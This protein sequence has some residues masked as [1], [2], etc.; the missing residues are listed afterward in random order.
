MGRGADSLEPR[1]TDL[2]PLARIA[3]RELCCFPAAPVWEFSNVR[4]YEEITR[5]GVFVVTP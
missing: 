3:S 4:V 2:W 1:E 5:V